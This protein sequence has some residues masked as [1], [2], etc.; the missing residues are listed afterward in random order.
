MKELRPSQL[1]IHATE[2]DAVTLCGKIYRQEQKENGQ[3]VYLK[4]NSIYSISNK[5]K[6]QES[7]IIIYT[8]SNEKLHIGNR[9][10]VHGNVAFFEEARNPGN[11]DQKFYYQKQKIHGK[12][13]ADDI[14]II[15]YRVRRAFTVPHRVERD[16]DPGDG[17]TGWE[18]SCGNSS[19]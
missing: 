14:K 3:T 2:G 18:D 7:N 9:I 19:G 8:N 11:F 15:D 16:A 12:I 4:H 10:R 6:F 13:W 1:E 17:R 5:Y